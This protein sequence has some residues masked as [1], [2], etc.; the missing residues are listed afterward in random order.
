MNQ[1][2]KDSNELLGSAILIV[3]FFLFISVCS[4]KIIKHNDEVTRSEIGYILTSN[5][6]RTILLEDI[7]IPLFQKSWILLTDKMNI[8]FYNENLKTFSDNHSVNRKIQRLQ[9]VKLSIEPILP[10]ILHLHNLSED[11]DDP[12]ILS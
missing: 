12:L 11:T 2:K 3:L 8:N 6:I 10:G 1:N 9:K 4:H 5:T 7:H